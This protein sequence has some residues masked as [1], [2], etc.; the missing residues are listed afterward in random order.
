MND[1]ETT[2]KKALDLD[3]GKLLSVY[4]QLFTAEKSKQFRVADDPKV[5][6]EVLLDNMTEENASELRKIF[7]KNTGYVT[8]SNGDLLQQLEQDLLSGNPSSESLIDEILC[9]LPACN[10]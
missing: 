8:F 4:C 2:R 10:F 1:A 9:R 6:K 7:Y 5:I 3:A